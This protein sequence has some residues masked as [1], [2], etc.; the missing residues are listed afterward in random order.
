MRDMGRNFGP[1][2][3]LD[4]GNCRH[5][6]CGEVATNLVVGYCKILR[7]DCSQRFA[8]ARN[9]A[10]PDHH[11]GELC[12]LAAVHRINHGTNW[13][14]RSIKYLCPYQP[15]A[16]KERRDMS[17][18]TTA[19]NRDCATLFVTSLAPQPAP[20]TKAVDEKQKCIGDEKAGLPAEKADSRPSDRADGE[21]N[22]APTRNPGAEIGGG[23][24]RCDDRSCRRYPTC[25]DFQWRNPLV[26]EYVWRAM[27]PLAGGIF[28]DCI[29]WGSS[30]APGD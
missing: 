24:H 23:H 5:L 21:N 26:P 10:L 19:F 9:A 30:T 16:G 13:L 12:G 4:R 27:V 1:C 3:W 18:A 2:V 14:T 20:D 22:E 8:C 7:R 17:P 11:V 6:S 25:V 29:A 15:A 28:P